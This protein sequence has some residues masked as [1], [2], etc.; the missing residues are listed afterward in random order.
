MVMEPQQ[1]TV[2]HLLCEFSMDLYSLHQTCILSLSHSERS[3]PPWLCRSDFL[4]LNNF[5]PSITNLTLG[6]SFEVGFN[7]VFWL[8]ALHAWARVTVSFTCKFSVQAIFS[9]ILGLYPLERGSYAKGL[10]T[11]NSNFLKGK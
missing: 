11:V 10:N 4:A 9:S 1:H 8:H 7:V 6:I 2:A 3:P 5:R